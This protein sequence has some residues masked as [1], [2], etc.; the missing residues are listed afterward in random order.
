M[1][2]TGLT[3][4]LAALTLGGEEGA[5]GQ[6]S[7]AEPYFAARDS[8]AQA[9][10][11]TVV[12]GA[13]ATVTLGTSP[14]SGVRFVLHDSA[15]AKLV[16][17]WGK[18][19]L[20]T[21]ELTLEPLK[22]RKEVTNAGIRLSRNPDLVAWVRPALYGYANYDDLSPMGKAY[23]AEWRSLPSAAEH[24]CTLEIRRVDAA[25]VA[26]FWDGSYVRRI[27]PSPSRPKGE[28]KEVRLVLQPGAEYRK[29]KDDT[30]G[31]DTRRFELVDL[32][33]NPR[34]KAF[35]GAKLAAPLK[36]GVRRFGD[37]PVRVAGPLDSADV[38]I[39]HYGKGMCGLDVDRYTGR[40]P[41]QGFGAAVHYRVPA[42]NYARAH[43]LFAFDD[44]GKRERL[45]YLRL[46]PYRNWGV[47]SCVLADTK[48]DL[49]EGFGDHDVKEIGA[50][51]RDGRRVPLYLL[52]VPLETDKVADYAAEGECLDF[53][54]FGGKDGSKPDPKRSSAFNLFGVTLETASF[55]FRLVSAPTAPGNVFTLD[56][57]DKS[58]TVELMASGA[59]EKAVLGWRARAYGAAK[60][61]FGDRR[62]VMAKAAG[63]SVS[64]KVDLGK[65]EEEG[66]YELEFVLAGGRGKFRHAT[67]FAV[68]PPAGRKAGTV[69]SPYGTWWFWGVH[70]C[71]DSWEVGGPILQKAGIR[72]T[73][74]G[75]WKTGSF[76]RYD[77]TFSGYVKAPGME[78]FDQAAK[79]FKGRGALDGEAW[80][81]QELEKQM[82][83][84]PWTDHVMVWHETAPRGGI[85]HEVLGMDVPPPS[86]I[87][88]QTAAY[89]NECGRIIRKH[90]PGHRIQIGNSSASL[91]AA[92][93]PF[94]GGAKAEYF[95]SIGIETPSQSMIPERLLVCG[96]QGMLISQEAASHYAGRKV[97][98]AGCYEYVYRTERILGERLQAAWY[99]RDTL[100]SLAHGMTLV[101]PA[102]LFD[103]SGAYYDTLWGMSGLLTRGPWVQPKLAYV[104]YAAL[105]KALDGV[106]FVRQLDTGSTTVY[107][108]A[109]KRVDGRFATAFWCAKGEGSATLEG[110][111]AGELTEM[112]GRTAKTA[113]NPA[114][115][116]SEEPSYLVTDVA[117]TAFRVT[118]RTYPQAAAAAEGAVEVV[119]TSDP[120]AFETAPDPRAARLGQTCLPMMRP[121]EHFAVTA[122]EDAERGRCLEVRLDK[123]AEE[124][125]KYYT[126]YTTLRLKEPVRVEA[127]D[128]IGVWVKG[129]SNWGQVRF[130]IEDAD[131]ETFVNYG[132]SQWWDS[133]DWQ[134]TLCVDFDGW[135][136]LWCRFE[137]G[138]KY[139]PE[140][141]LSCSPWEREDRGRSGTANGRIDFPIHVKAV[142][143]GVNRT[144]LDLVD[145]KPAAACVRLGG[146][147]VGGM[148]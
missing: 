13:P 146:I 109:F 74:H 133:V 41:L 62:Q 22:E 43:V 33:A 54:V 119:K 110:A 44:D 84:V 129:D 143:V 21:S 39:C 46:A 15:P 100:I 73:Q 77:V 81:V 28:V 27:G 32:A 108:L 29:L 147:C 40:N 19:G 49:R 60:W 37:V 45:L 142:T 16:I 48:V 58:V 47:G 120:A 53:E 102:L 123:T 79:A 38:A 96:L 128:R 130:E 12:A 75:N 126:E 63:E 68:L 51:V 69:A 85:P 144:K 117:P 18:G 78:N 89:V 56:E 1:S 36:P 30:A 59:G 141:G 52:S 3:V 97:P 71:P 116:F 114:V 113:A 111:P 24:V 145:F 95:D 34:A 80:F 83:S 57:R 20:E 26:L 11:G 127:A 112:C 65:A 23:L 76:E 6:L 64:V 132:H 134:G 72:K 67:R 104:A 42:R 101:S 105:T 25:S 99:M 124:V 50:V 121:S 82:K 2:L 91:G 35:A 14:R 61:A 138:V 107:A 98:L 9:L 10:G 70:G 106:S 90:F 135:A 55:D 131:G 122:V 94:R 115:R 87:D 88:R 17:D 148:K 139:E 103:V 137:G 8:I 31:L 4:L 5:D 92:F 140:T 7:Q 136:F 118:A 125:N 86:D 66:L 93:H